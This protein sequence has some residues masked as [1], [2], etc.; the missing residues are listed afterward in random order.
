MKP[1]D[2]WIYFFPDLSCLNLLMCLFFCQKG[3]TLPVPQDWTSSCSGIVLVIQQLVP[4]HVDGHHKERPALGF[5]FLFD[6]FGSVLGETDGQLTSLFRTTIL[7]STKKTIQGW[8]KTCNKNR[9]IV[10]TVSRKKT[11]QLFLGVPCLNKKP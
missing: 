7:I 3:Q 11:I 1:N 8:W 10:P 4:M 2:L 6:F 5:V 9:S